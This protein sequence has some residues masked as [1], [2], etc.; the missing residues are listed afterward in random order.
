MTLIEFSMYTKILANEC[1]GQG[2]NGKKKHAKSPNISN[3][4]DHTNKISA[5]FATKILESPDVRERVKVMRYVI[6]VAQHCREMNNFNTATSI[7]AALSSS[8]VHRLKKTWELFHEKKGKHAGWFGAQSS[9]FTS[10]FFS[11]IFFGRGAPG[12]YQCQG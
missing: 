9:F 2:W 4:I 5:W 1:L 6:E 11:Y 3:I 7:V 12:A 8:P 10:S